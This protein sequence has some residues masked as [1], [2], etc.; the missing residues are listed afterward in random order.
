MQPTACST[1]IRRHRPRAEPQAAGFD[2]GSSTFLLHSHSGAQRVIYLDF[3]GATLSGTAWNTDFATGGDCDTDPYDTDASPA[4]FSAPER[5]AVYNIWQR[6]SEDYALFEI[7]VTTE[8]PGAAAI[9]RSGVGDL[10]YGTRALITKSVSTCP[11]SMTLFD[12]ICPGTSCGGIAYNGVFDDPTTHAYYQPALIFQD[13]VASVKAQGEAVSHEVGHNLGLHHDGATSGCSGPCAYYSGHG[14]WAPIMGV[15]Y[16]HPITQ[17]SAGEYS[18][19]NNTEDD[20]AVMQ[21]NGAP[22]RAD[23]HGDTRLTATALAGPTISG[24]GT[25]TTRT[26]VDVFAVTVAGG[27]LSTFNANPAPTSPDLDIRLELRDGSDALITAADPPSGTD[28]SD[29]ATGLERVD[30]PRPDRRH[31]L[32]L[33]RRCGRGRCQQ[34]VLRLR[35]PRQLHDH[36]NARRAAPERVGRRSVGAREQGREEDLGVVPGVDLG[37]AERC[38]EGH[39]RNRAG[40]CVGR[41]RLRVEVGD[42]DD[43]RAQDVGARCD[44]GHRRQRDRRRRE[45]SRS[46]SRA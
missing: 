25:I 40:D 4:T 22:L 12:T 10:D 8:D 38:D 20:F 17:W 45:A 2:P 35:E 33:G 34:R 5:E 13:G 44:Q 18:I 1:S 6:V 32:P 23:D 41:V 31:L 39:L 28:S 14:S 29:V 16:T 19:A 9:D 11:N 43:W 37:C 15:G 30:Q 26:D 24:S 42:G 21:S 3:H 36:R 46:T 27:G 7:D